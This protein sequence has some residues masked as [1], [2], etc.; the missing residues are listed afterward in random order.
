MYLPK[1]Y[2]FTDTLILPKCYL[3]LAVLLVW[4]ACSSSCTL[5]NKQKGKT[6]HTEH[7]RF[8]A[9]TDTILYATCIECI[10]ALLHTAICG[11]PGIGESGTFDNPA[12]L[13]ACTAAMLPVAIEKAIGRKG[14][15]S[16]ALYSLPALLMSATIILTK[17]RTGL[18]C[19]SLFVI[20]FLMRM[21]NGSI[22]LRCTIGMAVMALAIGYTLASKKDS[23]SGRYFILSNTMSLIWEHPIAGHGSNGFERAYMRKQAEYFRLHPSSR[24]AMLADDVQH[25]L[26]E[27][28][29]VWTNHG[30]VGLLVLLSLFAIPTV[31]AVRS[32]DT[33]M[34]TLLL[35]LLA[36]AVFCMF[37]YPLRYP[38]PCIIIAV[39]VVLAIRHTKAYRWLASPANAALSSLSAVT[40]S[41]FLLCI[42]S[43]NAWYEYRWNEAWRHLRHGSPTALHEYKDLYSHFQDNR[44]F[45]YNYAFAL[46]SKGEFGDAIGAAERCSRFSDGYNMQLLAGDAFRMNGKGDSALVHYRMA[47]TMCPSRLAPLEGMYNTYVAMDSIRSANIIAAEIQ[48]KKIKIQSP[49]AI[50]I[51]GA[52]KTINSLTN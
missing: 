41:I 27:Y 48:D 36:V 11:L 42:L 16:K 37:S 49:D 18:L 26:N 40:L 35:P 23:T 14:C 33:D 15:K 39:S 1:V 10:Y 34:K 20:I 5:F 2:V 43:Y 32:K 21:A 51:K 25:P 17:S 29:Y 52:C 6:Q 9:A 38:L 47:H 12:G 3:C 44:Y 13:A 4:I 30:I 45:L 8:N 7:S 28:A 46:Y 22:L 19:L 50:R 24:N 31:A